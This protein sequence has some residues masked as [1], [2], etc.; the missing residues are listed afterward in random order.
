MGLVGSDRDLLSEIKRG[1]FA[2]DNLLNVDMVKGLA[3]EHASVL[4]WDLGWY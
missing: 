3:I 4:T 2:D 1:Q